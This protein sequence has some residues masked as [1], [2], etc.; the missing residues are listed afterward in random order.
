MAAKNQTITQGGSDKVTIAIN[1]DN[2][3]D[4]V[5]IRLN[6]LP[7]GVQAVP[8][9]IVIPAG[10]SSATVE[11][12]AADNASVGEHRVQ[13]DAVAPGLGENVQMFT[14]TVKDKG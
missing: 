9:E 10:S 6:D 4:P 3:N 11:L 13:I 7:Q 14:L 12:K 1:R 8:M 5:T 2:F